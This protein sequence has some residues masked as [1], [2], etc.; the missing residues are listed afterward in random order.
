MEKRLASRDLEIETVAQPQAAGERPY[1]VYVANAS[2]VAFDRL[3]AEIQ[4][5]HK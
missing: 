3:S 1:S 2:A 5:K 4:I